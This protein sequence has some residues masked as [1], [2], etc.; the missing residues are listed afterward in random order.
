MN[1]K[2]VLKLRVLKYTRRS[3]V[4]SYALDVPVILM[5]NLGHLKWL[6]FWKRE[7]NE[8]QRGKLRLAERLKYGAKRLQFLQKDYEV[9]R[10]I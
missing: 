4:F 6:D 7:F 8:K 9:I 5:Y 2:V 10:E 1:S 3:D